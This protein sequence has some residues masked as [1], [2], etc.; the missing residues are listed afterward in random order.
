LSLSANQLTQ[1]S[2]LAHQL[3]SLTREQLQMIVQNLAQVYPDW[4]DTIEA[5]IIQLTSPNLKLSQ[6]A[7]RTSIDPKPIEQQVERIIDRSAGQWN[8]TPAL[9]EIREILQKANAFLERG[10]GN[11]AL[12]ILGAIVRAYVQD[13]MNLDG[14]S[15]ES[16]EFFEELNAPLT[17]AILSAELFQS[18]R[19]K[20][21]EELEAWRSEV[22]DYGI[23]NGF[24]MSLMAS[25][26]EWNYPP[27]QRVLQGEITELG[28]MKPPI[29]QMILL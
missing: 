25:A 12:G 2:D 11:N 20:W 24:A 27:L 22:D 4:I 3:A 10:D 9:N 15:G 23:D 5:Q 19:K 29:L 18:D 28:K 7:R 17:E 21:Q 26:Q 8:D 1:R 16:G 6:P 13:W 14:S